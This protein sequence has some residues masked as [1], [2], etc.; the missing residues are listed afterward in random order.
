MSLSA[1]GL[2]ALSEPGTSFDSVSY[3]DTPIDLLRRIDDEQVSDDGAGSD[4]GAPCLG[5]FALD[6]TPQSTARSRGPRPFG[7]GDL[8]ATRYR[9][10][11][12]VARGSVSTIWAASDQRLARDVAVKLL[13]ADLCEDDDSRNRFL[14]EAR[15][16][17]S[18]ESRN[19]LL[20]HDVG[21]ADGRPFIVTELLAGE[22]LEARLKREERL[23][24]AAC[25]RLVVELAP[26]LDEAHVRGIV[27]R[28]VKPANVFFAKV[29]EDEVIVE[30]CKLLDFGV[31]KLRRDASVRTKTGILLA[32][33]HFASPEQIRGVRDLDG[34]SD[35]F[36]LAVVLYRCVTGRLPFDGGDF[37]KIALAVAKGEFVQ[38][39]H[40]DR[41]LPR[42]LDAFFDRALAVDPDDRFETGVDMAAAF[43]EAIE[44][45]A[46]ARKIA[47]SEPL[48]PTVRTRP[49]STD[50][51]D[52][53]TTPADPDRSDRVR[54]VASV[55]LAAV[56]L[57]GFAMAAAMLFLQ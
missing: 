34:R 29:L 12:R 8:V 22:D 36:S 54:L 25:Q 26:V 50:V 47:A 46:A 15:A 17:G 16:A 30:V 13:D 31:A 49:L 41:K 1:A 3:D 4:D 39:T 44:G 21:V 35:L 42:A 6:Q 57:L 10:V 53:P 27:H 38:P 14:R 23:S 43:V 45:K 5:A 55:A 52:D 7:P 37:V 9:L 18:I 2:D 51:L 24:L 32:S 11:R 28:D 20:V 19:A 40:I 48:F 56:G 33:P